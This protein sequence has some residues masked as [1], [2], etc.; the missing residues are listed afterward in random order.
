MP[1]MGRVRP[2]AKRIVCATN[3]KGL[4]TAFLVYAN[5]NND[6]LPTPENWCDLLISKVDTYP[7]SFI[8]SATDVI[9]GESSYALNEN[10]AGM[11]LSEI[12]EDVVLLFETSISQSETERDYP[13]TSR[14]YFKD[15]PDWFDHYDESMKVRKSR[16]NQVGGPEILVI[17]NHRQVKGCNILFADGHVEFVDD[18]EIENLRWEP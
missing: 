9:E 17:N 11:K 10:V 4:G 1:T 13:I 12:P 7:K 2:I 14:K 18:D 3:L 5:D 15:N 6:E 16:W 8:C